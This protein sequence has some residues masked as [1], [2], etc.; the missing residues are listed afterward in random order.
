VD[1]H[2][3]A[4]GHLTRVFADGW[5]LSGL[6]LVQSGIPF[7]VYNSGGGGYAALG[8]AGVANGLSPLYESYPDLVGSARH[9]ITYA[10]KA[11]GDNPQSFG[12]L[13]LNPS[14]FAA[15]RGLT[16]GDAGRNV[17]NNP[18]R[19]NFDMSLFKHFSLPHEIDLEFRAEAFNVFNH[20]R[21]RIYDPS[22]GNSASN[23]ISC[24]ASPDANYS[25]AGGAGT[26]CY[27]GNGFLHPFDAHRARTMQLA[28]KLAF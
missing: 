11:G 1:P 16:F 7:S 2:A 4:L 9:C 13:L 19:T 28:L 8:N 22:Q 20:T 27:T 10:K 6:T 17:L 14:A 25:A 21:F 12:P 5:D 23:T 15:P 3:G 24:Y 26:D 18:R